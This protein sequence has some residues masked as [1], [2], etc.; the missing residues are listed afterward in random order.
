MSLTLPVQVGPSP[1]TIN[2]DDRILVTRPD[3]RIEAGEEQG[4]FTSDT[5]FVSAYDV[6]L[7]G[8]PPVLLNAAPIRYFSARYEFTNPAL[9]G[10]SGPIPAGTLALRIDRTVS[11]GLH[12]DLD[13]VNYGRDVAIVTI[14]LRIHS[15]FADIFDVKEHQLVR[16]G[17]MQTRWLSSARE[18]RTSY[19]NRSFRPELVIRVERAGSVPQFA[20]GKLTFVAVVRPKDA[21]HVCLKWLPMADGDGRPATLGCSALTESRAGIVGPALPYVGLSTPNHSVRSAWEQAVRDME[22]LRLHDRQDG[23]EAVISAAGV[24]WFVTLFGRDALLVGMLGISGYPEFAAG[25]LE[26]LAEL[27]ATDH[28]PERDMEPG[29]IPHEIRRGELTR[30][31]LLPFAPYYGTHDATSL[32]V[33]LLSYLY[34]WTGDRS[35]VQRYL[36]NAEAASEWI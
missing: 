13:L 26:R 16:R 29:K 23:R 36:A 6:W 9:I 28:D 20:N 8:R 17:T 4:F 24:P 30:L 21:W 18:I 19:A 12:E 1:I 11:G 2:R 14:E 31:G 33:V 5:R 10:A 22:A 34:Q 27:Q 15:D 7:N 35:L 25:A 32:F 3:A